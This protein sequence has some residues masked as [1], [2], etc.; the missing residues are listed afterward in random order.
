MHPFPHDAAS[1]A[2]CGDSSGRGIGSGATPLP[3]RTGRRPGVRAVARQSNLT[4]PLQE[5]KNGK[6]VSEV[7]QVK[8]LYQQ[9]PISKMDPGLKELAHV[10]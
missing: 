5:A 9:P 4:T 7:T 1:R 8:L 2:A 10:E 6:P 3:S